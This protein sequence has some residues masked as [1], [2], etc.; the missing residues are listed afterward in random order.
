M[1]SVMVIE[2]FTCFDGV[3]NIFELMIKTVQV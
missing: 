1:L 2:V 3:N